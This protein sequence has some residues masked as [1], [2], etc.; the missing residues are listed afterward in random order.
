MTKAN[1]LVPG[2]HADEAAPALAGRARML[3]PCRETSD[4]MA[5][6]ASRNLSVTARLIAGREPFHSFV[7]TD[8]LLNIADVLHGCRLVAGE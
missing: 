8:G 1:R 2:H 6:L 3:A 5:A 7:A 4:L